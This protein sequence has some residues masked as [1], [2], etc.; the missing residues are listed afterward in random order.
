MVI[1]LLFAIIAVAIVVCGA[2]FYSIRKKPMNP[3]NNTTFTSYTAQGN[4]YPYNT[5]DFT[6]PN[7]SNPSQPPYFASNQQTNFS[8]PTPFPSQET[9]PLYANTSGAY[10]SNQSAT[11]SF[12]G[13]MAGTTTMPQ[14]QAEQYSVTNPTQ[15]HYAAPSVPSSSYPYNA[16]SSDVK[17]H[18]EIQP[19][20]SSGTPYN[21]SSSDV[22]QHFEIQY[23]PSSGTPYNASSSD[24]KQHF[25]IQSA[26]S[27]GT[28]YNA[29]SS[30]V[31]QHFEIQSAP[32]SSYPY[33]ASGS[34][35]KKP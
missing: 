30:D 17:Q 11:P 31:K 9:F 19:A 6:G 34:D 23:A 27:S 16:S 8:S 21:A 33:N 10:V 25:E 24:V 15:G 28:P 7:T 1:V 13:Y 4:S 22:K 5:N 20:P 14:H 12:A 32:S 2:V 35:I 3:K 29:S 18:F 26:P